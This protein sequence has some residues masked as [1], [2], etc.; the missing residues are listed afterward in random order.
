MGQQRGWHGGDLRHV[1]REAQEGTLWLGERRIVCAYNTRNQSPH[2]QDELTPTRK[3]AT[4][5]ASSL[6]ILLTDSCASIPPTRMRF[7]L[8]AVLAAALAGS[9]LATTPGV[10]PASVSQTVK[11]GASFN[12]DKTVNTPEIPPKPDVV[13]LVDV[14][15]SMGGSIA[16]VKAGLAT[17][18]ATVKADQ[19]AAQFAVA[20]FGDV[21]DPVPFQVRQGLTN[22]AVLLQTAVNSLSAGGGFDTPEDWIN[23]LY[24]LST[25]AVTYRTGSSRVIV[26]ISDAPSH[27]P[28]IGVALA[29]AITALQ[30][31]P[32]RVI[33][34]NVGAID[35]MGQATA[36]TTA[37]GG[38]I[39]LADPN[40]VSDAIVAGL[41][42]LDVAV[43]PNVV[44]CD[45]SLT[46]T[47]APALAKVLSGSAASFKETVTVA[48]GATQGSTLQCSVRF[49]LDGT[50]GGDAFVQSIA[51]TVADITP[52]TVSCD[53]GVNPAG[54]P[55]PNTNANFWTLTSH[56]N[57]DTT[58]SILVRDSASD[59]QFGPYPP[60]TNIK[61]VQAAG[62]TPNAKPGEGDV[63]WQITVKGCAVLVAKDAAGNEA[64]ANCCARPGRF[65]W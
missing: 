14:T 28:S 33:A 57:V 21:R 29:Q 16:N 23:A 55:K 30:A 46:I 34:V 50:P 47:F 48:A 61:L 41:K 9:A 35:S 18:I 60:G 56:D 20:S 27:D 45:P 17:V 53:A 63:N 22:D 54:K 42:N 24:Q 59:A 26:L 4:I 5:T 37:T 1:A 38:V 39:V 3:P 8:T 49:L 36:V 40:T 19:P 15:G 13:L 25:G 43:T 51:V 65:K 2:G 52:P 64:T 10:S 31:G 12:I 44:S 6:Q 11:P 58:V 62:A 32:V 7:A